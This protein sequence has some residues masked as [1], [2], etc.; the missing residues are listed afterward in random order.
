MDFAGYLTG[1]IGREIVGKRW[2]RIRQVDGCFSC[3]VDLGF[4]PRVSIC[5]I[6]VNGCPVG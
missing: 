4:M 1:S 5:E 3:R 6:G 2:T